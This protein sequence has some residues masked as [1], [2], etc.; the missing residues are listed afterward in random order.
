MICFITIQCA[1]EDGNIYILE[2]NPRASRT[3]PFSSK[4]RGIPFSKIAMKVM[5]GKKLSDFPI[6]DKKSKL[7]YVK[8]PVYPFKRFPGSDIILG[9]EMRSTGE[10]MGIGKTFPEAFGKSLIA[11]GVKLPKGGSAFLS[12]KNADKKEL[13]A[14]AQ[15]LTS[16]G[17]RLTATRGTADYLSENG[18]RVET[19]NKVNE[20]RP[21]I[22]AHIKNGE[23]QLV[24]NTSA[25]GVSEVGAA[26]ELRRATLMRNL[27]YFTTI[28]AARAGVGAIGEL[29]RVPVETHCLQ[30]R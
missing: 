24:I 30:E 14:I 4:A 13:V 27:C 7:F 20:G 17:F 6:L 10:V 26:Y 15:E 19:V 22:V 5:A 25:L 23:V 9:P 12:V 1:I 2:V 11:A 3:V 16:L 18:F 21:H 8:G 29:M 28:A